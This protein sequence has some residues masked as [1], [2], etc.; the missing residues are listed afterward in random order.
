MR[1]R[2]GARKR[3]R[4]ERRTL[5]MHFRLLRFMR[6]DRALSRQMFK[7]GQVARADAHDA[8]RAVP[9]AA[10]AAVPGV[11]R[12]NAA[13]QGVHAHHV[14]HVPRRVV[15]G[16]RP[17]R[18]GR[19]P[20]AR[21]RPA[22]LLT[23]LPTYLLTCLLTYLLTCLLTYLLRYLLTYLLTYLLNSLT[24]LLTHALTH[25]LTYLRLIHYY[26]DAL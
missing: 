22:Y 14:Q 10:H 11:R 17:A 16:V 13:R 26:V 1:P 5:P 25:S 7:S 21:V 3:R 2:L 18:Q 12:A 24:H 4:A 20:R 8:R 15:L 9:A 6:R 19:A 23:Y